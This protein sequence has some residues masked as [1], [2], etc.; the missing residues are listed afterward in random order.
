[1]HVLAILGGVALFLFGMSVMGDGLEKLS[2]GRLERFLERMAGNPLKGVLL[3]LCVTAVIQSSSATTVMV[4]GFVT[5][6]IMT[7]PQAV[8]IIMGANIGTTI[9]AQILRLGDLKDAESVLALFKPSTLAPVISAIGIVLYLMPKKRSRHDIGHF[10]LGFGVLFFGMNIMSDAAKAI[11]VEV[12]VRLF[13][14]LSN[15]WLGLLAGTLVTAIIQSSSAS[16]GILQAL[17]STGTVTFESS[18]PY[19]MGSNIGTCVTALI[20]CVGASRNAKR[21]AMIHLY[22]NIIGTALFFALFSFAR[23]FL[24]LQFM[25]EQV[26]MGT[27][28]NFHTVFNV[29][30]TLLLLPFNKWLIRLAEKTVREPKK[31][32]NETVPEVMP[33]EARFLN[34]PSLALSNARN[35]VAQMGMFAQMNYRDAVKCLNG[36]N[37]GLPAAIK[38]REEN[39]DKMED[40]VNVYLLK[41]RDRDLSD[42]ENITL[43]EILH[44]IGDFER[45]GD[46]TINLAEAAALMAERKMIF[47]DAA[48]AELAT[49]FD[50]VD[51]IIDMTLRSY[52]DI[53][54]PL[55]MQI[56]PLE[57]TI[58]ALE[59]ALKERHIDRLKRGRC[60][61]E[62]GT[63][64]LETVI[65]LERI[66]DHCSNVALYVLRRSEPGAR[67][68]KGLW[69]GHDYMRNLHKGN[70][71][72]YKTA[73]EE[74][75]HK[76]LDRL[77]ALPPDDGQ[78]TLG[79]VK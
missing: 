74:Y 68:G 76:Y 46:Y 60:S 40:M 71:P 33:L 49:I 41:L 24:D 28:A 26:N 21:A 48:R 78:L 45:I 47:S 64:L 29:T 23:A 14:I 27:I 43:S 65:N 1:M 35:M 63:Q 38:E 37:N 73:L 62:A 44:T 12:F 2:S 25:D 34:S 55:A 22:F 31:I 54:R 39:I 6:G 32:A 56:E 11:D 42:I 36:Q 8:G 59:N 7:L 57:Q 4:V 5:A 20:S 51:E 67:S 58:D 9:T 66:A 17:S 72:Q 61:V 53:D 79:D 18:A 75:E 15:P 3:G 30:T 19:V 77:N 52:Q 16:V 13:D 10:L 70:M 50:A 69:S